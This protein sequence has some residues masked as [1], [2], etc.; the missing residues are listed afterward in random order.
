MT[1]KIRDAAPADAATIADFNSQLAAETEDRELDRS[2]ICA[3][4]DALLADSTKGRCWV[5]EHEG[6]LVGQIVVTYEWSEWRNGMIWWI[7]C[8][9]VEQAFRRQGVF[10]S[11]YRHVESLAREDAVG[12]RLYVDQDNRRAQQTYHALGMV[13]SGYLVMKS[14]MRAADDKN[15]D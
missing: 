14:D 10:S 2:L 15:E 4:V 13:E 3:V 7:Q 6:R 11:M 8:V 5:A 12:L 9:Y 1:L